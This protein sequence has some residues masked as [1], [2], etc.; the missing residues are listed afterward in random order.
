MG[1]A[2]ISAAVVDICYFGA[3]MVFLEIVPGVQCFIVSSNSFSFLVLVVHLKLS[4]GYF[5][6]NYKLPVYVGQVLG[7]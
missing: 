7:F 3:E 4:L 5:Q 1:K 2:V 6:Y